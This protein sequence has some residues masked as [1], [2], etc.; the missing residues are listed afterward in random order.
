MSFNIEPSAL[1][2]LSSDECED[3][4]EWL[5]ESLRESRV[6]GLEE[7]SL[8]KKEVWSFCVPSGKKLAAVIPCFQDS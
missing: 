7:G 3:D 5:S 4:E 8:L 6:L 2:W 1:S